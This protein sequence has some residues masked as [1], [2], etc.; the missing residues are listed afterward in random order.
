MAGRWLLIPGCGGSPA[1]LTKGPGLVRPLAL[2]PFL[3]GRDELA[4]AHPRG[5]GDADRLGDS[6]KLGQQHRR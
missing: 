3:D 4:L 1:V 6:L 5:S 2:L